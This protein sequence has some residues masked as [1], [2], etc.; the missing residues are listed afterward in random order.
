MIV[1][2]AS[3]G[4]AW[5]LNV[6]RRVEIERLEVQIDHNREWLRKRRILGAV[7]SPALHIAIAGRSNKDSISI[8]GY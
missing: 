4:L 8:A 3:V 6:E 1:P 5:H 2:V 7:E